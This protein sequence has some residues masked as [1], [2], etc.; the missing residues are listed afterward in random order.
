MLYQIR[1][2]TKGVLIEGLYTLKYALVAIKEL[3]AVYPNNYY[4]L[5]KE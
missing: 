3:R 5:I 4:D 2:I 1:D